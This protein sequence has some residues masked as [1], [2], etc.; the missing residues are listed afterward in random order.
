M[1]LSVYNIGISEFTFMIKIILMSSQLRQRRNHSRIFLWRKLICFN[2]FE[3]FDSHRLNYSKTMT[4][5]FWALS[6]QSKF[7]R[8]QSLCRIS[9]ACGTQDTNRIQVRCCQH[10]HIWLQDII[11]DCHKGQFKD[12]LLLS[13]YKVG[14]GMV[15]Y[16]V[17]RCFC[18]TS[19]TYLLM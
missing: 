15:E 12:I 9:E 6:K 1:K 13:P 19:S 18:I 5:R 7:W 8:V 3:L 11:N 16:T 4:K 2:D 10:Q 17:F 14:Y